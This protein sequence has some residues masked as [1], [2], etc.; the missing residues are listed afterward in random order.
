MPSLPLSFH[1][2]DRS[3]SHGARLYLKNRFFE[4]SPALSTDGV[5]LIARPG[6]KR[7]VNVGGNGPVR[8]VYSSSGTFS[9]NLFTI[10]NLTLYRTTSAG[11]TSSI[12]TVSTSTSYFPSMAAIQNIGTVPE[13]LWI[14]DGAKLR[15]Y[16]SDGFATGTLT[17]SGAVSSGQQVVIS[18]VYYQW[19]SGAVDTGTPAGTSGSPWLVALGNGTSESMAYLA[20][21]INGFGTPGTDYSTLTTPNTAVAVSSY[22]S[23]T[24]VVAAK[25]AGT[26]GN[27]ITT[28]E[29][30]TNGSWSGATLSGGGSAGLF[31]VAVPE[32]AGAAYIAQ[33]NSYIIVVP[34]QSS[35]VNGQ[36]YWI[37]P[38]ESW[39]NQL[40]Y[41]TAERSPDSIKQAIVYGDMIWF[42]GAETTEAWV[43]TGDA[44]NPFQPF[45][46][47]VYDQ[48]AWANT[49]V[50]VKTSLI[51]CDPSGG[52]F[53]I[54][55]GIDRI[56]TPDI[57]ERIRQAIAAEIA[58]G[59]TRATKVF[60]WTYTLDGHDFYVLNLGGSE[61]VV[62]D[63]HTSE[64]S[65]FG[66]ST[67]DF[68]NIN[69][70][71]NWQ[72]A[73]TIQNS[74]GSDVVVG[75][76]SIATL[77]VLNPSQDTDDDATTGSADPSAFD[78]VVTGVLPLRGY[79]AVPC[80]G[81]QL[82]GSIGESATGDVTLSTSDDYGNSY[83]S[84]GTVSVVNAA[85]NQRIE[86]RSLGSMTAPG[87]LFK[88]LDTGAMKSIDGA[89]VLLGN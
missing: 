1:D 45:S 31:E 89:E 55:G 56:S 68:L 47:V 3:V 4:A 7:W 41:A 17:R 44:T 79:N 11:S 80:F 32:W 33:I 78:R 54:S 27:S 6:L 19:T 12:G 48:G 21:A 42:C 66:S 87:R 52:V 51:L 34:V 8:A 13:K 37:E 9:D 16:L 29:T 14:A 23:T 69:C 67:T 86:W 59:Y 57:E 58:A 24:V 64:W 70:G 50:Q 75:S 71:H 10:S 76:S 25:T 26:A 73:G 77:F 22:S 28:T 72:R 53:R 36:F 49:A 18:G 74:H 5:R 83:T 84:Q 82:Y 88:I 63:S 43:P 61:T 46:G 2:E 65:V 85:Y 38:G 35:G 40:N 62:F 20:N 81:I 30:M 60:A 39:I 15:V